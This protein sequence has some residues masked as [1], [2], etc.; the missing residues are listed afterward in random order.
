MNVGLVGFHMR[1][2]EPRWCGRKRVG[3]KHMYVK[4]IA[5]ENQERGGF[6]DR[7]GVTA[8]GSESAAEEMVIEESL[9]GKK[10]EI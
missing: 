3:E 7:L 8:Q 6:D 2:G 10:D 9:G 1:G 5:L 4:L